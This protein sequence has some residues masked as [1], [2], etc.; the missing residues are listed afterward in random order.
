[1]REHLLGYLIGALEP[2]ETEALE[3]RLAED[4]QL[5]RELD[6]LRYCL[7]PLAADQGHFDPPEGLADRTCHYVGSCMAAPAGGVFASSLRSW[8]AADLLVAAC[9]LVAASLVFFPALKYSRFQS[10]VAGCQNNLRQI[11]LA[12]ANYTDS[13]G[14]NLPMIPVSGKDSLAG[15][16]AAVLREE[17]YVNTPHVFLCPGDA[18]SQAAHFPKRADLLAADGEQLQTYRRKLGGS[19][20]YSLGYFH[21]GNYKAVRNRHRGN[22]ALVADKPNLTLT[23]G[24]SS[25]HGD[26]G[27]NVLFEDG[28]TKF[29]CNCQ[30][31]PITKDDIYHNDDGKIAPGKHAGDSVI[32]ASEVPPFGYRLKTSDN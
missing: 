14:G 7:H 3:S 18:S 32:A 20:G 8:R 9:V 6:L 21:E 29:L 19:Y 2:H 1:M 24:Q 28:S 22:F 16:H 15:V 11:G 30:A 27:Q 25:N 5:R 23:S 13:H 4:G 12:Y 10:H 31:C 26:K 17:G